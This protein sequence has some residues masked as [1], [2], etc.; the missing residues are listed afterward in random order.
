MSFFS[1]LASAVA[2]NLINALSSST[3]TDPFKVV[4]VS[5]T[6]FLTRIV[7]KRNQCLIMY[8][9]SQGSTGHEL[10]LNFP[11]QTNREKVYRYKSLENA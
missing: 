10:V 7:C 2:S 1:D 5:P 4:E 3:P 6:P 11:M 9:P 8:G